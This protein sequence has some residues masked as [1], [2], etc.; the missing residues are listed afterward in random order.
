[1]CADFAIHDKGTG[2][3]HVHIMLTAPALE[4]KW[5]SGAQSAA[6]HTIWTRTA[7]VSRM[8]KAVGKIIGEDTTDWNDK[9]KA[10]DLAGSVGGL[11]QP[12]AGICRQT[13]AH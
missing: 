1:M 3:P 7:S 5:R 4:R 8:G 12:G 10:G 9:G 11:H 6:R 13:G 2:N